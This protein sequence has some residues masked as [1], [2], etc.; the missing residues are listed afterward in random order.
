MRF[1]AYTIP[2]VPWKNGGGVTRELAQQQRDGETR[3]RLSLADISRD[4][5]FSAFTGLARIHCIVEGQGH[6]L[7]GDGNRLA[8]RPLQ[9]LAFDGGLSLD[10]HLREGPCT[11]F[12]LIYNPR[13]IAAKAN[14]HQSGELHGSGATQVLYVAAGKIDLGDAGSLTK[15]EGL[16]SEAPVSGRI[17]ADGVVVH[18]QLS[19]R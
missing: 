11:A 12:N 1:S 9:P 18:L 17:S 3:W 6:V 5:P 14:V 10:C 16:V 4:G 7:T 8:A 13:F 2:P 15:G 19:P